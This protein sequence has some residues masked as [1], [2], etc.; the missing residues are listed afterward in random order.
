V[1]EQSLEDLWALGDA[2]LTVA[3]VPVGL[4]QFNHLYTGQ[5]MDAAAARELLAVTSRWQERAI[6]AKGHRWVY[7]SD[8]LYLLA[9]VPLPDEAFYGEFPQIENGVGAVAKLRA[10]VRRGAKRLA[11]LDGLRIGVVT[12][13]AM[14]ALM[15]GLLAT[16]AEA[17]GAQ[18]LLIPAVNSLFG[19]TVT[20]AGLLVAADIRGV[21]SGRA[22]ID[23][24]LIPAETINDAGVFLDDESLQ[25]VQA[26]LPVPVFPSHDFIDA[27]RRG[28]AVARAV[29]SGVSA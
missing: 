27:L 2:A 5:S 6:E 20:T 12:G 7:G 15:P 26:A 21:L 4:T 23:L 19:P 11:R 10:S 22:D 1:L 29:R 17:T 9:G 13:R 8:E 24:A 16:L 28:G 18:F 14:T 3:V 25:A